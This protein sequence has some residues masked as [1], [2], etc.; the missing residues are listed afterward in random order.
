MQINQ[1]DSKEYES[2]W[3]HALLLN[4][5]GDRQNFASTVHP[6]LMDLNPL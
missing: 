2:L 1:N 4:K 5:T 3:L 6:V